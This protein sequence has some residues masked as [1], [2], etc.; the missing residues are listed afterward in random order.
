MKH[1]VFIS[2]SHS[3]EEH[4]KQ[5]YKHLSPM[6]NEGLIDEWNDRKIL[7]GQKWSEEISNNLKSS[8]LIL[9][10]ISPDF[11]ASEYCSSYEMEVAMELHESK[12]AIVIPIIVRHSDWKRAPFSILQV[13]PKDALPVSSWKDNDE[14]WIDVIKGLRKHFEHTSTHNQLSVNSKYNNAQDE[15]HNIRSPNPEIGS[16]SVTSEN[17]TSSPENYNNYTEYPDTKPQSKI[18]RNV[19]LISSIDVILSLIYAI[20]VWSLAIYYDFKDPYLKS[21]LY[22]AGIWLILFLIVMKQTFGEVR[23]FTVNM[24]YI[25]LSFLAPVFVIWRYIMIDKYCDDLQSNPQTP[26]PFGYSD[27]HYSDYNPYLVLLGSLVILKIII[28][29]FNTKNENFQ[30]K[31][32]IKNLFFMMIWL[33]ICRIGWEVADMCN[34]VH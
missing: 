26:F 18:S 7:P 3:D 14:A 16:L 22:C 32:L 9:L 10:L 23:L 12:K 34:V 8:S 5:L 21:Y 11:L 4:M 2:Y 29:V 15:N 31:N 33:L 24:L 17:S 30:H 1:K 13:M 20:T 27:K 28:I 19:K 6:K 25:F